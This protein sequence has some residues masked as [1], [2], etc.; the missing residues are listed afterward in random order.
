MK[1]FW[2]P[3]EWSY[4]KDGR[5]YYIHSDYQPMSFLRDRWR[6]KWNVFDSIKEYNIHFGSYR[7][8]SEYTPEP[9]H[10]TATIKSNLIERY[11]LLKSDIN[12]RLL[13][14]DRR[15]ILPRNVEIRCLV[16][17]TDVL[18]SWAI[19]AL[20]IKV[21][22]CPGR[23]NEVRL[24]IYRASVFYGQCSEICGIMHGFMPIVIQSVTLVQYL[25]YIL[26]L[27]ARSH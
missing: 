26:V 8:A 23:L 16:T 5:A 2:D 13:D 15:L 19:P 10:K 17:S 4:D 20:G 24:V 14:V 18:H 6:V 25:K 27:S 9:T 12:L 7:L 3:K 22:A 1:R 11:S 21:D